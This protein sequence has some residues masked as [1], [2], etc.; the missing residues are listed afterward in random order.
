MELVEGLPA[1]DWTHLRSDV[2]NPNFKEN[3]FN[4]SSG[5]LLTFLGL[6]ESVAAG[7]N[8]RSIGLFGKKSLVVQCSIDEAPTSEQ[9]TTA[10]L[11]LFSA[12]GDGPENV[13]Q[14]GMDTMVVPQRPP[15][16]Q[17]TEHIFYASSSSSSSSS[18]STVGDH[19]V[20]SGSSTPDSG[21]GLRSSA[22]VSNPIVEATEGSGGIMP[23][24]TDE[25][26][27]DGLA[28]GP[29]RQLSAL[30][31]RESQFRGGAEEAD[32]VAFLFMIKDRIFSARSWNKF[33]DKTFS[34]F[35]RIYIHQAEGGR[36][37]EEIAVEQ[38]PPDRGVNV[39]KFFGGQFFWRSCAIIFRSC[40]IIFIVRNAR[41]TCDPVPDGRPWHC[42]VCSVR[43]GGVRI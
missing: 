10:S 17:G 15:E 6:P 2:K 40:R 13:D 23:A 35:F 33:F 36:W 24:E 1:R 19:S 22:P 28:G 7:W 3:S 14:K 12:N 8:R 39:G 30:P 5:S 26:G 18:T 20:V 32:T 38:G 4:P 21:E 41:R 29:R 34:N 43:A 9:W 37:S 16:E 27:P 42:Q 11:A 25:T 31:Y